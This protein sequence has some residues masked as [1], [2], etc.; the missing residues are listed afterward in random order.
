MHGKLAPAG[1]PQGGAAKTL[2]RGPQAATTDPVVAISEDL[3]ATLPRL[4]RYARFLAR[5]HADADDLLQDTVMRIL[6]AAGSYRQGTNFKAWA[7]M[8]MRNRF[9]TV[10]VRGHGRMVS[11]DDV[12]L[13]L[14]HRPPSQTDG[15]EHQDLVD[16]FM[17]LPGES[18]S[19][20]ALADDTPYEDIALATGCAVGTVKSRVHRARTNLRGMLRAA[21]EPRCAD[22]G[23][24]PGHG[25]LSSPRYTMTPGQSPSS[26]ATAGP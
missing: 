18:R 15:L 8:V 3:M 22:F 23:G 6:A 13:D 25:K 5:N 4:S 20:L 16:Q 14:A 12:V 10:H 17:Q 9:L 1:T 26:Q 24:R 19:L 7:C 2:Q 21:Y 11:I